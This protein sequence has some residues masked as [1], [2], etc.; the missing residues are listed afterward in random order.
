M[1]VLFPC[2]LLL[3]ASRAASAGLLPECTIDFESGCPDVTSVCGAKF[4]GGQGCETAADP[5]QSTCVAEGLG[6]HLRSTVIENQVIADEVRV[7]F[8]GEVVA[9]EVFFSTNGSVGTMRF[10]D[11]DGM[12]VDDEISAAHCRS[13]APGAM[14][15]NFSSAI[16][17]MQIIA[18]GAFASVW[19]D[20]MTVNPRVVATREF[21]L[22]ALKT[23]Y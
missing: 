7:E 22:G 10:F 12:Q 1:S 6:Y 3:A 11:A 15:L 14:M 17:S 23:R 2:L 8:A 16:R 5:Q 20:D 13:E 9:L 19:I 4:V 21:S 18:D